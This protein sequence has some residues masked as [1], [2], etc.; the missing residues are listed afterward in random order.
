[1]SIMP[2]GSS[3]PLVVRVLIIELPT[4]LYGEKIKTDGLKLHTG[5]DDIT[6]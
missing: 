1:M 2:M 4:Y 6:H 5:S 3:E